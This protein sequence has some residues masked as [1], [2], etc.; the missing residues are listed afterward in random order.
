MGRGASRAGWIAFVSYV[1]LAAFL[2]QGTAPGFARSTLFKAIRIY[3]NRQLSSDLAV[4]GMIAGLPDGAVG[5]VRYA[6]LSSL[7][8]VTVEVHGDENFSEGK[9]WPAVHATGIYLD[10]LAHALGVLPTSD[11]IDATCTDDYR[12]H[13]PASYLAEHHPLLVLTINHQPSSVWA[14]A[15]HQRDPGPYFVTHANFVPSFK[16]LSHADRPQVPTGVV[17]LNFSTIAATYGAIA[18]RGVFPPG[19]PQ[20]QGFT[21]ARQNCLRCHNQGQ[22]GG[23]KAGR[24]WMTLSTWAREQPAYFE[25]Y[26]RDPKSFEPHAKMPGNPGYDKATLDALDAYFRTFTETS[27]P[28]GH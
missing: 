14:K 15:A 3:Q 22:Y 6:D 21:I 24:T 26:V 27:S 2:I 23:L 13:Y 16:V 17:R 12:A 4:S 5:Y 28:G 7:P 11:L 8:K 9:S 20:E 25:N 19:S 10:V 18:P 1:I